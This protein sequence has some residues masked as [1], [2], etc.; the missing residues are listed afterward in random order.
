MF[1]L[2]VLLKEGSSEETPTTS[3][4]RMDRGVAFKICRTLSKPLRF[5]WH[6]LRQRH[7]N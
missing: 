3:Q 7:A 6:K 2:Y 1:T 4:E 5:F